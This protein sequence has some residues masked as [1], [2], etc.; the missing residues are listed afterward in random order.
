MNEGIGY[1]PPEVAGAWQTAEGTEEHSQS[2]YLVKTGGVRKEQ[3]SQ[4]QEPIK[5]ITKGKPGS[6]MSK[7]ETG[8]FF[9]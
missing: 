8:R 4:Q 2:D 7:K 9:V 6:K 3:S 1:I 5:V